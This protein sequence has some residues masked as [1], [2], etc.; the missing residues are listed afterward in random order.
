MAAYTLS[1]R[2]KGSARSS[3]FIYALKL[4]F[5]VG[6]TVLLIFS[7]FWGETGFIRLW[8]LG[9]KIERVERNIEVLKVQRNDLLWETEKL[10]NDPEYIQRYAIETYGYAKP[11]QKIIQFVPAD[12]SD[13]AKIPGGEVKHIRDGGSRR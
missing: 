11:D 9:E 7:F 1:P 4:F 8:L 10:K 5:A 13:A 12:S 3:K 2:R 6:I